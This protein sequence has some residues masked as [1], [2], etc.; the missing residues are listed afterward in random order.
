MSCVDRNPSIRAMSTNI[1]MPRPIR[2]QNK[3]QATPRL[4]KDTVIPLRAGYSMISTCTYMQATF[5]SW[6][7]VEAKN[8][9][10]TMEELKPRLGGIRMV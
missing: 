4:D 1:W 3:V 8:E 9:S 6:N 7:N 10:D 2:V 5:R